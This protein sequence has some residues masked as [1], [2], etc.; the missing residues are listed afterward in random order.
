MAPKSPDPDVSEVRKLFEDLGFTFCKEYLTIYENKKPYGEIDLIFTD[1]ELDLLFLISVTVQKKDFSNKIREFFTKWQ[2]DN[3]IKKVR[4]ELRLSSRYKCIK[5]FFHTKISSPQTSYTP[6]KENNEFLFGKDEYQYFIHTAKW[7]GKWAKNDLLDFLQISLPSRLKGDIDAIKYVLQG[8]NAYLYLERADKLLK[9]CCISRRRDGKLGYQRALNPNRIAAI[10]KKIQKNSIMAFPNS[11]LISC[12]EGF[13]F[14]DGSKGAC[15]GEHVKIVTPDRPCACYVV[16][17]QHR[18]L[19]FSQLTPEAQ[20]EHFI[21]VVALADVNRPK[22]IQTFIE[23]N[24]HQ[25]KIDINLLYLLKADFDWNLKDNPREYYEK[26][27]VEI[28]K[29]LN[30]NTLKNRIY[31]PNALHDAKRKGKITLATL[32]QALIKNNFTGKSSIFSSDEKQYDAISK[33]FQFMRI[34]LPNH[35]SEPHHFFLNNKG[36]RVLF[37]LM[38]CYYKNHK[39]KKFFKSCEDF[40]IDLKA[41]IDDTFVTELENFY[42]EGGAARAVKEICERLRTKD[43]HAYPQFTDDLRLVKLPRIKSASRIKNIIPR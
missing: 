12:V 33:I 41:I 42:G 38:Q 8:T 11:I 24:S 36:L 1:P 21:P 37:R 4:D 10:A 13:A 5:L 26:K 17:G 28:I 23:I 2:D 34:H 16:D 20:E 30:Q 35:A 29:R 22:E 19:S 25:K 6:S 18:L 7:I 14:K 39:N 43:K 15:S 40:I 3:H 9:Y 32:A 27:T 31:I